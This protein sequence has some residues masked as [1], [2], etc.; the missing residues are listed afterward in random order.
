MATIHNLCDRDTLELIRKSNHLH[1]GL[2]G[3]KITKQ[4]V[5]KYRGYSIIGCA[6][7]SVDK[8]RHDFMYESAEPLS[9]NCKLNNTVQRWPSRLQECPKSARLTQVRFWK[10][11][12]RRCLMLRLLAAVR[13]PPILSSFSRPRRLIGCRDR[14]RVVL[15]LECPERGRPLFGP[16]RTGCQG[17]QGEWRTTTLRVGMKGVGE[18][19]L[20]R[21]ESPVRVWES[22]TS[23][24]VAAGGQGPGVCPWRMA[25]RTEVP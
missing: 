4:G 20:S 22:W 2:L 11:A 16:R 9:D 23:P 24:K 10:A 3:S 17:V 25:G 21:A 7:L 1:H 6:I 13:V 18:T 19:S 12:A 14:R 5:C 8:S 15:A